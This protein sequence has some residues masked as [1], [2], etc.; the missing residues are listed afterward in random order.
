MAVNMM[1]GGFKP[2]LDKNI[3][4]LSVALLP[5][6]VKHI[7]NIYKIKAVL[8]ISLKLMKLNFSCL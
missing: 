4:W 5:I 2:N 7:I 3:K 1:I 8:L 6:H